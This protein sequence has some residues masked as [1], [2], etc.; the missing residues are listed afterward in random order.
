MEVWVQ[1]FMSTGSDGKNHILD[2]LE[3][4]RLTVKKWAP[5][6]SGE[7]GL[8]FMQSA[9]ADDL[10]VHF[11]KANARDK[12]SRVVVINFND[13]PLP[14]DQLMILF[15]AGAEY[16]FEYKQVAG[17]LSSIGDLINCAVKF[18]ISVSINFYVRLV[19]HLHVHHVRWHS[20]LVACDGDDRRQ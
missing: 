10:V 9:L 4:K 8:L 17:C 3:K 5:D 20:H 15:D 1:D 14:H 13:T 18:S 7:I 16:A 11:L 12:G 6:T 2:L 19:T